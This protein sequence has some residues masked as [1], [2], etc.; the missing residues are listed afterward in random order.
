[1]LLEVRASPIHGVGGFAVAELPSGSR[2]VE[3]VGNRIDKAESLRQCERNNPFIFFLDPEHDLDGQVDWNPARF[4]N[5]S[6]A[7]NCDAELIQ[8]RIWIVAKRDI[9]AGEEITF[10]YGY[11]FESYREHPC[12]CGAPDCVGYILAEAFHASVRAQSQRLEQSFDSPGE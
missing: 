2:V 11:D 5:H 8:G 1:M 7:P 4:L 10:N 9:H 3:Y 12:R 6:C